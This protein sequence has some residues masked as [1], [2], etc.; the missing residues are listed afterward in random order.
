MPKRR[1]APIPAG[2]AKN[3]LDVSQKDFAETQTPGEAEQAQPDLSQVL[4]GGKP[5]LQRLSANNMLAFQHTVGNRAVL[6]MLE[7]RHPIQRRLDPDYSRAYKGKYFDT[8]LGQYV[9]VKEELEGATRYDHATDKQTWLL[10]EDLTPRKDRWI[11]QPPH[12]P[13]PHGTIPEHYTAYAGHFSYQNRL[14]Q[15]DQERAEYRYRQSQKKPTFVNPEAVVNP[16]DVATAIDAALKADWKKLDSFITSENK[17]AAIATVKTAWISLPPN[18][19]QRAKTTF[20]NLQVAQ[21]RKDIEMTPDLLKKMNECLSPLSKPSFG[22]PDPKRI[23]EALSEL[24]HAANVVSTTRLKHPLVLGAQGP[25]WS[26]MQGDDIKPEVKHGKLPPLDVIRL[27]VDAYYQTADD[28]LHIDEVKDTPRALAEKAKIGEQIGRQVEWLLGGPVDGP[29]RQVGYF[30]QAIGPDFNDILDPTVI[31]NLE[32]I[33]QYQQPDV[34]FI[35]IANV[36]M[37]FAQLKK[38]YNDALKWLTD[39]KPVLDSK[40]MKLGDA[41]KVYFGDIHTAI[42]SLKQGHLKMVDSKEDRK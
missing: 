30:A 29:P 24:E 9:I 2:S 13:I 4:Q 28:V 41:A 15:A 42:S 14:A 17:K 16:K 3:Q 38:M 22:L 5:N 11:Y 37:T 23:S 35:K 21:A 6:R 8:F 18:I 1:F 32:Q 19:E 34:P 20:G 26:P 36:S 12:G 33:E 25:V 27:E 31:K 40:K 39:S 7:Q 10:L